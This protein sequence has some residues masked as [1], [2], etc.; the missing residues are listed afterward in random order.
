MKILFVS[1]VLPYPLHSGGQIRI[2]NL[3]KRLGKKHEITLCAFIR[4]QD[5]LQYT[6]QFSFC[7][8]VYMIHRGSAWQPQYI[9]KSVFGRY[10]FLMATYDNSAMRQLLQGLLTREKYDVV[11]IEPFYVWPSLP[12]IHLPIV[13]G[14]HNIEYE[15]YQ[16]YVR[17]FPLVPLRPILYADTLKLRFW[18]EYVWRK[19]AAITAVSD[20]DVRV[21]RKLNKRVYRVANGVDLS[22]FPFQSKKIKTDSFLYVGNFKWMEN[23]DAAEYLERDIWPEIKKEYPEAQLRII[24][25]ERNPVESIQDELYKTDIM[26]APIR[27]GGG[28]KFKILEAMASGIPVIT[29]TI[30]AQGLDKKTLWIAD[31]PGEVL[32]AIEKISKNS[33]RI[34]QAR[35]IVKAEYNWDTIAQSLEYVWQS[36]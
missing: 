13:V 36:V 8:Y 11:H 9:V 32:T 1:A 34:K 10:P 27:I 16:R 14:E 30:G 19:A 23:R 6:S 28:T 35:K 2:Y 33:E 5:E 22:A 31:T 12:K 18:E 21:I 24:G 3:L 29:T 26:I 20:S 7:K 25:K 4:N 17:R 15:V